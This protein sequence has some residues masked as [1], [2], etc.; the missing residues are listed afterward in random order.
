V[1]ACLAPYH[2]AGHA[3]VATVLGLPVAAVELRR[4]C[5]ITTFGGPVAAV[6]GPAWRPD[7]ELMTLD[8]GWRAALH[9]AQRVGEP[10]YVQ[11]G[12]V[13]AAAHDL[14]MADALRGVARSRGL[15]LLGDG[16]F[17]QLHASIT[18]PWWGAIDALARIL[19]R[20]GRVDG[21]AVRAIV[22]ALIPS[23]VEV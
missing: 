20:V 10:L 14:R 4:D 19:D 1:S 21:A 3:V 7:R 16:R 18:G 12:T 22:G 2:E 17:E 6:P 9:A 5:G 11:A 23:A 15:P 8:A 13:L